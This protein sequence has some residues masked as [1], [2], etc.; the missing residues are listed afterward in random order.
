MKQ[1]S[2][3]TCLIS[4]TLPEI[5]EK[6]RLEQQVSDVPY[7]EISNNLLIRSLYY[8]KTTN[9]VVFHFLESFQDQFTTLDTN[10][11]ARKQNNTL[12]EVQIEKSA[13]RKLIRSTCTSLA[14]TKGRPKFEIGCAA[15]Q[16]NQSLPLH[17]SR[18]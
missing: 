5:G 9:F 14:D 3:V 15:M 6:L 4:S 1:T 13:T 17:P 7:A 18:P 11:L 16:S 10:N 12:E 2:P 8:R